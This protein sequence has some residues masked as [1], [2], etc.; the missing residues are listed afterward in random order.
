MPPT[1]S[2]L[3]RRNFLKQGIAAGAV[4][5]L[6]TASLAQQLQV[7][8]PPG[9]KLGW[10]IVGLGRLSINQILPA[11]AKCEKSRVVAF[12]TGSREKGEKLAAR[13]GVNPKNIYNYQTYDA[14]RDNPEVDII[15]IVL[16]NGMHAEYTIRGARAGKHILTEKPMANTPK[17]CEEMIA[18]AR[19]A[20]RKLMVAYRCRYEPYN[21]ELIKVSRSGD[22]GKI[23]VVLSDHGFNIG[24][25]TQWRLNK[26]LAGGGSLMD[27]GLYS[28]QAACYTTGEDPIEVSAMEFTDRSDPR[29]KEVED[30]INFQMRFPS[31][32]LAQCT[33]SYGYAG[34]S[35]IRVIGAGG[36]AELEPATS[37]TGLRMRV[38]LGNRTEERDL[39]QRDHFAAEMDHLSDCVMQNK[40]VLTPGEEGLRDLKIMTA[41]YEAA[42]TGKTVKL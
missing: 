14:L 30:V 12:V 28:L 23:R 4:G 8:E 11:F 42:R 2:D 31:G 25:P 26:A 29:F 3:S 1:F 36:W 41:I 16:P 19:R 17:D 34:Q 7:P 6:A 22:I 32:A 10:A 37:Y 27:I 5:S 20:N 15:Y 9:R 39:P 18:E 38:R 40:D 33:S 35:R 24:D 21:N 13:Y